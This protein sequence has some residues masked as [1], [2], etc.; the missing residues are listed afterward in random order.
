[1]GFQRDVAVGAAIA[2]RRAEG[3]MRDQA[4]AALA[5]ARDGRRVIAVRCLLRAEDGVAIVDLDARTGDELS[6]LVV[7]F[8]RGSRSGAALSRRTVEARVR[9][10][11]RIPAGFRLARASLEET[12]L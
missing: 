1:M 5:L 9:E 6:T 8:L 3:S 10:E 2:L 11:A 7:P 4:T 12:A